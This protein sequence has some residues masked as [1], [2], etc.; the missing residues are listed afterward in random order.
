MDKRVYNGII[1]DIESYGL[2]ALDMGNEGS[3]GFILVETS[4]NQSAE[5]NIR[6][7]LENW[8]FNGYIS[9]FNIETEFGFDYHVQIYANAY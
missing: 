2:V 3:E 6:F 4:G 5:K 8:Q 1:D 7:V 9:D